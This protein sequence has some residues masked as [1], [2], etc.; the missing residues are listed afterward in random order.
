M[1][2]DPCNAKLIPGLYGTSEGSLARLKEVIFNDTDAT[3]GYFLWAP[4]YHNQGTELVEANLFNVVFFATNA[5]EVPPNVVQFGRINTFDL[6]LARNTAAHG[7]DPAGQ[8]L[9]E[10]NAIVMDARTL[11]A[12]IRLTYTGRM[13]RAAGQVCF[14]DNLPLSSVVGNPEQ[15][16]LPAS[17]DELFVLSTSTRRFGID[18]HEIVYR[19]DDNHAAT[20][21][22]SQDGAFL[23][24]TFLDTSAV[25]ES[26]QLTEPTCFGFGWRRLS[27]SGNE[28]AGLS[29][30]MIKNIE[31]RAAP[32]S[33][34]TS[35]APKS[36]GNGQSK[37]RAVHSTLDQA[38]PSWTKRI[39][40]SVESEAG[41]VIHMAYTGISSAAKT[42]VGGLF[43]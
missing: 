34:F 7:T 17:V 43:G 23:Y 41:K 27:T 3:S 14:V 5:P 21:H 16:D 39:L 22:D 30:E 29:I 11:S 2:A 20:F 4:K 33:G 28:G 26:A 37:L 9:S 15:K 6:S 10:E 18:T 1:V 42:F 32:S 25:A 38:H 31:W 40:D 24:N 12:C 8:L 19:A 36:V 13:E 35:I